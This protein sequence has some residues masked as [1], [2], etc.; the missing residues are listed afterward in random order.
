MKRTNSASRQHAHAFHLQRL[1][2]LSSN[3]VPSQRSV[4]LKQQI[5]I[6]EFTEDAL[7]V[8]SARIPN[9][10][11]VYVEREFRE[12]LEEI[13][14]KIENG[15]FSFGDSSEDNNPCGAVIGE[16]GGRS[17]SYEPSS[18]T[19]YQRVFDQFIDT[20]SDEE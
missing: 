18:D 19:R 12:K 3:L 10:P 13:I 16:Q 14:D 20:E 2:S 5:Q 11:A 1:L 6:G 7:R 4:F 9:V 17:A 15:H 8:G